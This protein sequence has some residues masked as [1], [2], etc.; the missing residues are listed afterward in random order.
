[1]TSDD[2]IEIHYNGDRNGINRMFRTFSD[3][4]VESAIYD[5]KTKRPIIP[6]AKSTDSTFKTAL[7]ANIFNFKRRMMDAI[8]KFTKTTYNKNYTNPSTFESQIQEVLSAFYA[9]LTSPTL[10]DSERN[11]EIFQAALDAFTILKNFDKLLAQTTPF[12]KVKKGFENIQDKNRYE[13]VGADV[14]LFKT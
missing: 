8:C 5:K 14:K 2:V 12:I 10:T 9:K 13:Y 11:S 3:A 7:N 6:N 1:M 4:M